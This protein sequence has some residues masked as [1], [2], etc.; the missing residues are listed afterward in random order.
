M[1]KKKKV[2][3]KHYLPQNEDSYKAIASIPAGK[4]KN[5]CT[6][7]IEERESENKHKRKHE[8]NILQVIKSE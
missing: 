7:V 8:I 4:Y 5:Y 6:R 3:F 2:T 1:T